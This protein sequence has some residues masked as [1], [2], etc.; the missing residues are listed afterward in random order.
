MAE[1]E[2][3][4]NKVVLVTG[5]SSGI[6]RACA[7][8][9]GREGAAVLAAG[10]RRDRLDDVARQIES[11]GGRAKIATGDVRDEKTADALV[12]EAV[13]SFGGLDGVIH[14]AG[15]LGNGSVID[16]S[17]EEWDRV[18]DSNVRS[19]V[20]LTRA[21]AKPLI[22]RKGA[23]VSISSVASIRPYAN[24]AAYCVSKAA[25]DMFT[26]CAA[27][28]FAPHGVRVNAVNPGVVVTELHTVTKAVADYAGFLER[29]KTTHPIGRVGQ[30]DE[31]AALVLFL[32]SDEA[33]W[34]TGDTVSIDGGRA[35]A[36]A[37]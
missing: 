31:I 10:R 32:L 17:L 25:V 12:A 26:R 28:D 37:R 1:R 22:E 19:I 6:G 29:S 27:L 15:V 21:A 14:G 3:F 8:A 9:L 18:M 34:I 13:K 4:K 24:L 20:L 35:L 33:G 5:A 30:P 11:A 2:R 23:I 36:S 16:G 7:I